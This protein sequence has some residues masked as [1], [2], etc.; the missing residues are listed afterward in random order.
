M[1]SRNIILE[2]CHNYL[3]TMFHNYR[4]SDSNFYKS[5]LF[6]LLIRHYI[7]KLSICK[8]TAFLRGGGG[9]GGGAFA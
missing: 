8:N 6:H 3:Y 9:G 2:M 5:V 1:K 4:L 7:C